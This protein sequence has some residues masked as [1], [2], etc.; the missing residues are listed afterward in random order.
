M[1]DQAAEGGYD[2]IV[3]GSGTGGATISRELAKQ[4]KRVLLLERGG[5]EPLK[6]TLVGTLA[7]ART[8]PVGPGLE[9]MA[10][11]TVGGSTSLYFAKCVFPTA[12]TFRKL[13]I[14]LSR[15]LEG[16]RR[17]LPIATLPDE[18]LA[19]QAIRIRDSAQALGYGIRRNL[20]LVDQ[21]KCPD[22][23]YVYEAKWKARSYVREAVEYGAQL[24]TKATAR[25]ILVENGRAIGVEY[26]TR[27]GLRRSKRHR[28]YGK[29]IVL[30][31]GAQETPKFLIDVGI[32]NVGDHGFFCHPAFLVCGTAPGMQGRDGFVAHLDL[33]CDLD[34][35]PE[36]RITIGDATMCAEQFRLVMLANLKWRH[37]F[38]HATTLSMGVALNDAMSGRLGADGR[39]D[40]E[41]GA[42]ELAMLDRAEQV[43]VNVLKHAGAKNIFRTRLMGG[44]PGGVLRV[45][46]HLDRTLQ[47]KIRDLY[48]CDHSLIREASV[49]PT[50]LLTCLGRYLARHL[51][52]S[53]DG[54]QHERS[55]SVAV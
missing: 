51:A 32:R 37:L 22:G 40:K 9:G 47:T 31:A 52:E 20:L 3:V 33:D 46:E 50:I 6:E 44:I 1:D 12:E 41:L 2:V 48:V 23:K 26:E 14:D 15:E 27:E 36:G 18:F 7:V 4:R 5:D 39:Y 49:T 24:T 42:A 11:A 16:V 25:K 28:V 19:P 29:K 45:G 38:A 17:E 34:F 43:A 30:A 35:D 8:F 53:L 54:V 13:G 10:A 21:S 55:Y